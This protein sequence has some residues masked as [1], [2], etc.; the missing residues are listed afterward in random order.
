MLF[1]IFSGAQNDRNDDLSPNLDK[2][3]KVNVPI[4]VNQ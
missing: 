1:E 3:M 2:T 4:G